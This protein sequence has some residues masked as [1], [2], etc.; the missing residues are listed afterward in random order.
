MPHIVVVCQ[1]FHPDTQATSQLFSELLRALGGNAQ[2]LTVVTGYTAKRNGSFPPK[3]EMLG[4]VEIRR[5]GVAMDYKRSLLRRGFHYV[6]YL[7]GATRELWKLR[8]CTFVFG[9]TNP[10]FTPV[11]LWLLRH[12]FV[13]RYQVMLLDI[14]PEGLLGLGT[15][16]ARSWVVRVWRAANRK[17]LQ[18]AERVLVLGRDMAELVESAYGR[19]RGRIDYVP[20]WGLLDD[21]EPVSVESRQLVR[22]LGLAGKFLVQY[23]GNMGLWHD[24]VTIVR[25]AAG[26]QDQTDIHFLMIGDGRRLAPSRHLAQELGV[27]N[28]TWLPF[29]PKEH[30]SDSLSSCHVALISQREG[31]KGVAV[32]CKLYG[33]LASGRP[34]VAMVPDGSEIDLVVREE[35]CG[36]TIAPG[37]VGGLIAAIL[38][39][40]TNPVLRE[41][42]GRNAHRAYQRKYTLQAATE[43]FRRLWGLS[44]ESQEA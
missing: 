10:P 37:D 2:R 42:M 30:L 3:R 8:N 5:T 6:C 17:A 13:K 20:H 19:A 40:K 7:A 4:S 36:R 41:Q 31:L 9:V 23:S 27:R 39:L 38:D 29:Q 16:N 21:A 14:Y 18:H 24:I 25:A 26:L 1:V 44:A 35:S 32:P 11:W 43:T 22:D 34:V 28:M 33:I 12:W 15:L